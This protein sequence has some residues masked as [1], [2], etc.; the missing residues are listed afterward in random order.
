MVSYTGLELHQRGHQRG[1]K[2]VLPLLIGETD[3]GSEAH[4]AFGG[5]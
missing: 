1:V 3:F 5:I 2:A 4:A